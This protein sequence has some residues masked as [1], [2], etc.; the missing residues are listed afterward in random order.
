MTLDTS[1]AGRET[2]PLPCTKSEP[3]LIERLRAFGLIEPDGQG[4]W[5][6]T[7]RCAAVLAALPERPSA[8]AQEAQ[9]LAVRPWAPRRL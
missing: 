6:P 3:H 2:G 7:R 1:I 8:P 4:G 9:V 5:Q